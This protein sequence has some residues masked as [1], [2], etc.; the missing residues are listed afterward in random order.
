VLST[1]SRVR[2]QVSYAIGVAQPL[3]VHVDTYG[4]GSIPDKQ[5]LAAV[6][7]KFDFRPGAAALL[8]CAL[9]ARL[10]ATA[11]LAAFLSAL[12]PSLIA[13]VWELCHVVQRACAIRWACPPRSVLVWGK[14]G[15]GSLTKTAA[16]RAG[17]IGRNLDL[18]RPRYKKTAAYGHFGREPTDVFTWEKVIDLKSA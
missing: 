13:S 10:L 16:A 2:A 6:L 7:K 12:W 17:M 4:T 3:S 1:D 5:I 18:Y 8:S 9:P 14:V 15:L 11:A